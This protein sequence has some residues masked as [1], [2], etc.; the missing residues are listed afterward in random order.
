MPLPIPKTRRNLC[1]DGLLRNLRKNFEWILDHRPPPDIPQR[2]AQLTEFALF[3][4]KDSS[5][6]A[7]A[8]R[9]AEGNL[10]RLFGIGNAP[11]DTRMREISGPVHPEPIRL[12][13]IDLFRSL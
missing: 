5:L 10:R 4:L 12:A 7:F 13:F 8:V 1:A 2:D 11:S 3:S 9:R 6:L